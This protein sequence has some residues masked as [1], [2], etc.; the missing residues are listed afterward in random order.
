MART[1][2]IANDMLAYR[3]GTEKVARTQ[4]DGA[5]R[6]E[7]FAV[8]KGTPSQTEGKSVTLCLRLFHLLVMKPG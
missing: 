8:P 5:V 7:P 3:R 6:L 1:E 2:K 4:T